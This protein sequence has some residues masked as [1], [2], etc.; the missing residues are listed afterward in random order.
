MSAI[1]RVFA[2][3]LS[4]AL[5]CG[6]IAVPAQA[7]SSRSEVVG[8]VDIQARIDQRV[9]NEA[10]QRQAIQSLLERPEVRR[11]AGSAGIDMARAS[12]AAG[13][14]SGAELE[15]VSAHVQELNAGT[16]GVE[17]VT[18]TVTTIIIILLLIIILA[19]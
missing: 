19:D 9:G 13:T 10:A 18:L 14:L 5:L 15:S 8:E 11:I 2:A 1:R 4:A 17:R 3:A 16:G 12:A 6:T 7:G